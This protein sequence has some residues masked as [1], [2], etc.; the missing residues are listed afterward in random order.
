MIDRKREREE[1]DEGTRITKN[2]SKNQFTL[3]E[4]PA[5]LQRVFGGLV[6]PD[7]HF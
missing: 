7:P 5:H 6:H 4:S 2:L 3:Y 1:R